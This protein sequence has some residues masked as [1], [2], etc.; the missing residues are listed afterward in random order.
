M[1]VAA[2]RFAMKIAG[3]RSKPDRICRQPRAEP[4]SSAVCV[5]YQTSMPSSPLPFKSATMP[6]NSARPRFQK[7][8]ARG[9]PAG[10][11]LDCWIVSSG[12]AASA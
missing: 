3:R 9:S 2:A 8:D 1:G 11:A 5:L 6:S 12:V 10:G 4:V 7:C